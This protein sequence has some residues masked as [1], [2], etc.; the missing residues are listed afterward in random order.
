LDGIEE[1]TSE[2]RSLAT[3]SPDGTLFLCGCR[4]VLSSGVNA[5]RLKEITS[6][7]KNKGDGSRALRLICRLADRHNVTIMATV[8]PLGKD[9]LSKAELH[10]W[11]RR[12]GFVRVLA[13][14]IERAP[15]ASLQ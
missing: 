10:S 7:E 3:V 2:L 11:Y 5:V 6:A 8:E 14:D 1:F 15:Q 9:G 13:D 12:A 4:I